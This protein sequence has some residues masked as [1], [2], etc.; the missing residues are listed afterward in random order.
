VC[1]EDIM[2]T[3]LDLAGVPIPASV[4][5]R[6]LAPLL[7]GEKAEW[8]QWLHSEY[9]PNWH[10]LT[11]GREKYIWFAHDGREQLFDLTRD[12]NEKR[13]LA[14]RP[15]HKT[16]AARWRQRLIAHLK[17]RPE[18]FSDGKRLISGRPYP[19][20]MAHGGKTG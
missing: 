8:R 13:N 1:L 18:G 5:G 15:S 17:G 4:D 10:S 11:D 20:V 7:R 12:P 2:P 19:T 6:S 9:A 3:L 16:K 14:A